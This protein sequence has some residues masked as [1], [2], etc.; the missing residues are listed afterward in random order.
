MRRVSGETGGMKMK[1][2]T[3]Y[4]PGPWTVESDRTTVSF[5]G[6]AVITSPAPDGASREESM[7]NAR[8]IAAAPDLL[9]SLE[10][11][12]VWYLGQSRA[13][14]PVALCDSMDAAIARATG[15]K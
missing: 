13:A 11:V 15:G 7:A 8:L 9:S 10:S 1:T 4:T 6:Q 2:E 5:G 14:M 12:K 3:T